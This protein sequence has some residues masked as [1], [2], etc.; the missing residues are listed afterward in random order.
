M[1]GGLGTLGHRPHGA[2][3]PWGC[4][5]GG[6]EIPLWGFGVTRAVSQAWLGKMTL[7]G[8]RC[9]FVVGMEHLEGHG[10]PFPWSIPK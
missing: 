7:E 4:G 10:D 8:L 1:A 2:S 3:W 6:L 5:D 9:S